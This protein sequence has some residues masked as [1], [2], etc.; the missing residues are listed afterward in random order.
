MTWSE[1]CLPG[2]RCIMAQESS[3]KSEK[4]VE[5]RPGSKESFVSFWDSNVSLDKVR[6]KGSIS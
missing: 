1:Y 3:V 6:M 2:C 4:S 5:P